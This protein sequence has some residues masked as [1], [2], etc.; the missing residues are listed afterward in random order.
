MAMD[1]RGAR[2]LAATIE[3]EPGWRAATSALKNAA[4][5]Q[6]GAWVALAWPADGTSRDATP[7]TTPYQWYHLRAK[8][9]VAVR[10]VKAARLATQ[11]ARWER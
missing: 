7:I 2:R 6:T 4:G 11:R 8:L 10:R 9:S 5:R 1:E 3:R